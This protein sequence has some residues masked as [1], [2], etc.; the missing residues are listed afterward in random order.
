MK[1]KAKAKRPAAPT[2]KPPSKEMAGKR[3][4]VRNP[5][6]AKWRKKAQ[7]LAELANIASVRVEMIGET[8]MEQ[9]AEIRR[10]QNKFLEMQNR[11]GQDAPRLE[12]RAQAAEDR[13]RELEN[14]LLRCHEAPNRRRQTP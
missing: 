1:A 7:S 8:C 2:K 11:W 4:P 10:L 6:A 3:K 5:L 12:K 14:Q 9:R 13:V